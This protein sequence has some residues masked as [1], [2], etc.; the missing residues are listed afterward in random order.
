MSHNN[1]LDDD[2]SPFT[3]HLSPN[4]QSQ[5]EYSNVEDPFEI[6]NEEWNAASN[7]LKIHYNE[8]VKQVLEAIRFLGYTC[9]DFAQ[10][11]GLPITQVRDWL[12][13]RPSSRRVDMSIRLWYAEYTIAKSRGQIQGYQDF[14]ADCRKTVRQYLQQDGLTQSEF[15]RA[16]KLPQGTLSKWL[17]GVASS[18]R[19][20]RRC[21]HWIQLRQENGPGVELS[22]DQLYLIEGESSTPKYR[23]RRRTSRKKRRRSR[24][25]SY[26]SS[27][28]SSSSDFSSSSTD[29]SYSDTSTDSSLSGSS[30][31]TSSSDSLSDSSESH[32]SSSTSPK[33][34]SIPNNDNKKNNLK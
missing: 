27:D 10:R 7:T 5:P 21:L 9:D 30:D 31:S 16:V 3:H 1:P 19:T 8:L 29:S 23:R 20:T 13:N 32:S 18:K 34:S 15:A 22:T 28:S 6:S 11:V 12:S 17:S 25:R 26:S 14:I 24:R 33:T 4:P 2:D